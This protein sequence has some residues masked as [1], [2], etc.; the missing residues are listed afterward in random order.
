MAP[1]PRSTPEL[2]Y[3]ALP[4]TYAQWREGDGGAS[5]RRAIHRGHAHFTRLAQ[6]VLACHESEG[7]AAGAA[8]ERLLTASDAVCPG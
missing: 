7:T 8:I 3:P 6:Q 5:L 4:Q 1:R 2:L